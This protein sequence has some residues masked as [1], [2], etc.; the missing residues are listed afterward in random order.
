MFQ[1][2]LRN[3]LQWT[4]LT[5]IL[6]IFIIQFPAE[7]QELQF[8]GVEGVSVLRHVLLL[9]ASLV[10]ENTLVSL[11]ALAGFDFLTDLVRGEDVIFQDVLRYET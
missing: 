1:T 2:I 10:A 8:R 7:K 3:K 5:G 4:G 9:L 11:L 6:E